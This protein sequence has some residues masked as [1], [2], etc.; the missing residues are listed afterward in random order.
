MAEKKNQHY[1][2]KCYQKLFSNDQKSIGV[3][4]IAKDITIFSASIKNQ[5]SRDYF[6][7]KDLKVEEGLDEIEGLGMLTFHKLVEEHDYQLHDVE[8]LNVLVYTLIQLGRTLSMSNH[9]A[10]DVNEM[11]L[12]IFKRFV[13]HDDIDPHL[14]FVFNEPALFSLSV[15]ADMIVDCADLSFKLIEID[16]SCESSFITSDNPVCIINP[17]FD[18]LGYPGVTIMGYRGLCLLMTLT[19]KL[20]ILFYDTYVYKIRQKGHTAHISDCR[21]VE[22]INRIVVN[23]ADEVLLFNPSK[24]LSYAIKE[25]AKKNKNNP[26][27]VK[28]YRHNTCLLS[29]VHILDKAKAVQINPYTNE[30]LFRDHFMY[31]KDHPDVKERLQKLGGSCS[32]EDKRKFYDKLKERHNTR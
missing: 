28:L 4:N 27:P 16:K 21:E 8:R 32:E 9:L 1:V 24:P 18:F 2:P 10:D 25:Y 19:P 11:S 13:G 7:S 20:A 23:N 3:Y 14:R 6:Y 30:G 15:Y 5:L 17:Y 31:L 29:F 26:K 12:E 22:T